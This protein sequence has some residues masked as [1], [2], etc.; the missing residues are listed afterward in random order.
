MSLLRDKMALN[1][2]AGVLHA[3]VRTVAAHQPKRVIDVREPSEFTGEL[4]HIPGAELVPLAT[5]PDAARDWPRDGEL[6]IVCRSGG[7]STNA[8]QQLT[9]LG[10][11]HVINM[12]GGML[13]WNDAGLP[14]E[15]VVPAQGS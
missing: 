9:A 11:E 14:C 2:S 1:L 15:R 5:L 3:E 4:G 12:A 8:A 10:F 7:R 6:I 13:A